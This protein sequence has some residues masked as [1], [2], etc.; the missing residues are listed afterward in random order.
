MRKLT[1]YISATLDRAAQRFDTPA[2]NRRP[3]V[4]GYG[5]PLLD[6]PGTPANP[7][8]TPAPAFDCGLTVNHFSRGLS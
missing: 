6:R 5:I 1:C 2:A 8:R 4:L 7:A 3:A